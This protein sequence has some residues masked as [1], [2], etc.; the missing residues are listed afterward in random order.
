ML[1]TITTPDHPLLR[2]IADDPVRPEIQVDYRV[3]NGRRVYVLGDEGDRP[4][5]I[6]CVSFHNSVPTTVADLDHTVETPTTAV[7]YTIWSYCSG[8]GRRLLRSALNAIREQHPS[9][10][11]FVT[12]SPP[13]EMARRFHLANGAVVF[14]VNADTVNYRYE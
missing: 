14:S 10:N 8:A 4:Q 13:T 5:A 12:L 2:Y 11:M 1:H 9:V 7:A 6:V 3:S